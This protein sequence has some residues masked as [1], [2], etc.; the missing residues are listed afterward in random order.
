MKVPCHPRVIP[1]SNIHEEKERLM[2]EVLGKKRPWET[3][4]SVLRDHDTAAR[5]I[6]DILSKDKK[7]KKSDVDQLSRDLYQ[8]YGVIETKE[9]ISL[10]A[11]K[12]IEEA[13]KKHIYGQ[14]QAVHELV[15][16]LRRP[17]V[18]KDKKGNV[19]VITGPEGTGKHTLLKYAAEVFHNRH[20]FSSETIHTIDLSRYTSVNEEQV[21]LQDLYEALHKEG[22]I[23]AFEHVEKCSPVFIRMVN[24]F[25]CEGKLLL[26]KRYVFSNGILVE[27]QKGLVRDTVDSLTTKGKYL[28]FITN[29]NVSL[30]QNTFGADFM[31]HVDVVTFEK[32]NEGTSGKIIEEGI[33]RLKGQC[34]DHLKIEV[35]TDEKLNAWMLEHY[36]KVQGAH[37][38]DKYISDF[39][40]SISDL[41]MQKE[42][43]EIHIT[44]TDDKPCI[45]GNP[46]IKEKNQEE[47]IQAVNK[48]LDQIIGLENVKTYIHSLQANVQ[49]QARRRQQGLKTASVSMH[50]IFTGN[51]GTGKTTI[52]RLLARYLKASGVLSEGQLV[53]VSRGDLV[54]QYAGQTAPL[55]MSVIQSAL[56]G[57]LFID[58]AYSLYRGKEDSFGLEAIDALVKA[59]EDNRDNLIVILAGYKKEMSVFLEANSG[60]K[61]RFSKIID[62]PDYTGKELLEIAELQAESKGYTIDKNAEESLEAYFD[63]VQKVRASEAGN[64]RFART[65][66]EQAVLHQSER[67]MQDDKADISLLKLEDFT[68]S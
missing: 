5:Q 40:E 63:K 7:I 41:V 24:A 53:E 44:V 2:K 29:Q 19:I 18:M 31:R 26:N 64:G 36:D 37:S 66:V 47:E 50:M 14:D 49:I 34:R 38:I 1:M 27:N 28:V 3:E 6:N 60:L 46:L 48:E 45:D 15:Q 21:F 25:V 17:Y 51:P 39:Y 16:A 12:E 10:S 42:T 54:A 13:L 8:D 56:G 22:E 30:I 11:S 59:M 65:M 58:E 52:A 4:S 67:V 61:S 43:K 20:L 9:D 33:N 23:I 55:T 57:I 68:L 32:L 62:F 35:M